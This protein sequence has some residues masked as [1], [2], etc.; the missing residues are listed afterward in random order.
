MVDRGTERAEL[1]VGERQV[2]E[3]LRDKPGYGGWVR[4]GFLTDPDCPRIAAADVGRLKRRGLVENRAGLEA[5]ITP[6]GR[7]ALDD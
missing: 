7:E 4:V 5:R 2:L 1:T 3:L 6:A